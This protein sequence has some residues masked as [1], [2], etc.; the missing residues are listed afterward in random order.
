MSLSRITQA[1]PVP[2]HTCL[3]SDGATA[4]A[5]MACADWP[6]KTGVKRMP[7]SVDFQTPPEAAP[8]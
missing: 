8:A 4:S 5:P 3:G 2:A 7:P 6:S 1:S